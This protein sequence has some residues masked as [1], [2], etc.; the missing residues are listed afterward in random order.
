[1][2][3]CSF[4]RAAMTSLF[5]RKFTRGDDECDPGVPLAATGIRPWSTSCCSTFGLITLGCSSSSADGI[6]AKFTQWANFVIISVCDTVQL[7]CL[8]VCAQTLKSVI[9][10]KPEKRG[11]DRSKA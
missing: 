10:I 8:F 11:A 4:L 6:L 2:P 7:C 9:M 1:M 3:L 5:T